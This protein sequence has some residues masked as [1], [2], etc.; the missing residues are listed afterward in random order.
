MSL[1][2]KRIDFDKTCTAFLGV[3]AL[4][5][6]VNTDESASASPTQTNAATTGFMDP[7]QHVY[8]LCTAI[9]KPFDDKLFDATAAFLVQHV[10]QATKRILDHDDIVSAYAKEWAHY[11]TASAYLDKICEYLNKMILKKQLPNTLANTGG[12]GSLSGVRR[13]GGMAGSVSVSK[14]GSGGDKGGNIKFEKQKIES[15]AFFIWKQYVLNNIKKSHSN[16]LLDQVFEFV[17]RDRDGTPSVGGVVIH[18]VESFVQ[19]NEYMPQQLQYYIE[20]YE[21]SYLE[22]TKTYYTT[23]SNTF[24]STLDISGYMKKITTRLNEEEARCTRFCHQTSHE[25]I[26]KEC[27][28][29]C[30]NAHQ[31]RILGEFQVMLKNERLDDARLAYFLMSRI[32]NGILP[33]LDIMQAHIVGLGKD[34]VDRL[35]ASAAKDPREFITALMELHSKYYNI[36][37]QYFDNN[38]S[39]GAAVDKAFRTIV[40]D[41]YENAAQNFP[42]VLSRYC[43]SLLKKTTKAVFSEAEL[44]DKISRVIVIFKY[45]DEK[46]VFQKFYSR[47]LAKR[48]IYAMS[49]SD[50]V[51][52]SLISGLKSVCGV[53]Y[54]QKLQRMFTDI[55]LSNDL[56]KQ[57]K[58]D[59]V[60]KS[61]SLGVDF[62]IFV[63][64]SGS[65]PLNGSHLSFHI[66]E[67]LEKSVTRF[68][69][70][71]MN[72]HSGR[73]LTWMY[74]LS[75]A[76]VRLTYL[77][78]KYEL[79]MSL[80]QLGLL[81]L[82]NKTDKMLFSDIANELKLSVDDIKRMVKVLVDLEILVSSDKGL[83]ATADISVNFKFSNKRTKLKVSNATQSETVAQESESTRMAVDEDRKI[84]LQATIVRILKSRKV[85]GHTQLVQEVI[86]LSNG[87]FLP[88]IPLIKKGIEQ[89]IE[90]GYMER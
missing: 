15:L 42:E 64:T 17:Q 59:S 14:D 48:L 73:R 57:F 88:S 53:E 75:K 62:S 65:W 39:F 21:Q 83:S 56:N 63:L 86:E 43:D 37:I 68:T 74:H 36:C 70:F 89:L 31:K 19:V 55:T 18:A 77:D 72:K 85:L 16:R 67:E 11:R 28:A 23:E 12:V 8:Y 54:T 87:R 60:K 61:F 35:R 30:I 29:Q 90:K 2:G 27:E 6:S 58:E 9:P 69:D 32:P 52:M 24:I 7:F 84:F 51:E 47:L 81:L 3:V 38:G 41:S 82:F 5:F 13:Y 1:R 26:M 80:H 22:S 76:D 45:L 78:K 10:Q 40:N 50:D 25:K 79:N 46:D 4:L 49:V 66:P 33:M 71:Y 44:E 20:E 34:I